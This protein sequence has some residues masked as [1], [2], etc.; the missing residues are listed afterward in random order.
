M[1]G[2]QQSGLL[3][4]KIAD[5]VRDEKM[6]KRA[7]NMAIDIIKDDPELEKKENSALARHLI[8]INKYKENWGLIS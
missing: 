4:L 1:E 2:T 3:D 5:I 6:L 8:L 7:R